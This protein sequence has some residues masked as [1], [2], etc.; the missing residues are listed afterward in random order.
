MKK[1]VIKF[2]LLNI[3][4][5]AGFA[6]YIVKQPLANTMQPID[7]H[8]LTTS[9]YK[10]SK[11]GGDVTSIVVSGKNTH[12]TAKT[13]SAAYSNSDEPSLSFADYTV[14]AKSIMPAGNIGLPVASSLSASNSVNYT[15]NRKKQDENTNTLA[16]QSAPIPL[17]VQN[18]TIKP[19]SS[20]LLESGASSVLADN[21]TDDSNS[22]IPD[23]EKSIAPPLAVG[24]GLLLLVLFGAGYAI[25]FIKRR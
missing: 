10:A 17:I 18:S 22:A 21:Y 1:T 14:N 3:V 13:A 15:S 25:F 9:G 24:N 5:F 23:R 2:L 6:W 4:I 12:R 19:V 7:N 8:I 16:R 20:G 11:D